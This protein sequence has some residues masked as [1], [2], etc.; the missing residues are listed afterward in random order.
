MF[1]MIERPDKREGEQKTYL[2][3]VLTVVVARLPVY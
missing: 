1:I 3:T 2:L